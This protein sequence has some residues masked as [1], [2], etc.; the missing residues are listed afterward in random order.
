MN[1]ALFEILLPWFLLVALGYLFVSISRALLISAS[2][3]SRMTP[4][5]NQD[6]NHY[7]QNTRTEYSGENQDRN[8]YPQNT[9]TEYADQYPEQRERRQSYSNSPH[10]NERFRN[11]DS[12]K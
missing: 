1:N 7:Q 11:R 8:R 2:N 9:D 12:P 5:E 10:R 3:P 4:N 6:R